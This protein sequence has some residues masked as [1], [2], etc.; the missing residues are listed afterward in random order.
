MKRLRTLPALFLGA[1]ALTL[2]GCA[3]GNLGELVMSGPGGICGLIHLIVAVWA[4]VQIANS[5]ADTGGKILW[6]AI[7]F[8]F[9]VGGLAL[10]YFFGPK[11]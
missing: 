9:P 7:V 1:L 8:F 6:A 4:L 2:T 11:S 3:G 5:T 10:W